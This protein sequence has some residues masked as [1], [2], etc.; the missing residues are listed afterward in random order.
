MLVNRRAPGRVTRGDNDLQT[1][2]PGDDLMDFLA[3]P[4][5]L[6]IFALGFGFLIFVHELGH[7]LAAKSVGVKCPQFAIGFGQALV[8]FRKGIGFKVGSTEMM[9]VERVK[10]YLAEHG[11]P[12]PDDLDEAGWRAS[13]VQNKVE[14]AAKA[15]GLGETEYRLNWMPLGGYVKMLGQEDMDPTAVSDDPRAFNN[16]PFWPRA[17]IISA[18][19]MMNTIFASTAPSSHTSM[20]PAYFPTA[21]ALR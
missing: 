21:H 9:F 6:L 1:P 4:G 13:G 10:G 14:R 20:V 19:V 7:F 5:A 15:L 12:L 11:E 2:L 16:Q 8:S 3:T 17:L 18:G